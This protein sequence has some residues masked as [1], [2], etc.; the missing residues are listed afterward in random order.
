MKKGLLFIICIVLLCVLTGCKE[1]PYNYGDIVIF[2]NITLEG[3]DNWLFY[4]GDNSL[5]T[6]VGNDKYSIGAMGSFTEKIKRLDKAATLLGKKIVFMAQP[7]KEII[8]SEYMPDMNIKTEYRRTEAF[9]DFIHANSDVTAIYPLKEMLAAKG[10]QQL[11]FTH[12]TH[13]N[14]AG[15]RVGVKALYTGLGL[16]TSALDAL[17]LEEEARSGGD[18]ISLGKLDPSD[19]PTDV[20]YS[21]DYRPGVEYTRYD[22]YTVESNGYEALYTA[23]DDAA[24]DYKIA[25]I[26]D[27]FRM[28]MIPYIT[29]DFSECLFIHVSQLGA[30]EVQQFVKDADIIVIGQ[31]ERYVSSMISTAETLTALLRK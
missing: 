31:V 16:D 25:Y 18:L 3:K 10:P 11:Y 19:Y 8:Y 26:G 12:D 6:Y 9:F 23:V 21:F 24:F 27:S 2:N 15:A 4:A 5:D 17:T 20:N 30:P 13:W 14:L 22:N 28:S 7:N 29:K 1:S